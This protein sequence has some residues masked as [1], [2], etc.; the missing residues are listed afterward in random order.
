MASKRRR[1][2]PLVVSFMQVFVNAGVMQ[3]TV[4]QVDEA[5]R[6]GDE[7]RELEVV[8][9]RRDVR[10]ISVETGVA[11]DF[12]KEKWGGEDGHDGQSGICLLDF[13]S[14]LILEELW[15]VTGSLV[16][17]KDVRESCANV[18][19]HQPEYPTSDTTHSQR[20]FILDLLELGRK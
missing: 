12:G 9:P 2:D 8:V 5:I 13:L 14:D 3:S 18:V 17:D 6:E 15:V 10:C 11:P 16:E 19:E 1:H 7:E 20:L 4:D